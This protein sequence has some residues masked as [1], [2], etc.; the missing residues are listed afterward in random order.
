MI[1]TVAQEWEHYASSCLPSDAGEI[2]RDE[3]KQAF[4]AGVFAGLTQLVSRC[5]LNPDGDPLGKVLDD[6]HDESSEEC[7]AIIRANAMKQ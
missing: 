4:M 5:A 3:T 6:L 2:Q 7:K 1:R